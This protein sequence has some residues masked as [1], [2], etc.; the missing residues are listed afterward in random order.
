MD[1]NSIIILGN[2]FDVALGIETRYSQFYEK[3]KELREFA[4]NGN[5][6][7]QHILDHIKSELWSDLESGL[8]QYSKA[9][10]Q[11]YG[12]GNR[13]QAVKLEKEFNELRTALFDYLKTAAQAPAE[14]IQQMPVIGLNLEW[15]EL[16]PQFLTFNY[17]INTANTA[18]KNDRYIFN[19]DDS[20]NENR[21]VY[22]HGSIYDTQAYKNRNPEEIVVGID[23]T[24][25]Q[26]EPLHSFLYKTQQRLHDIDST[27]RIIRDKSFYVV[28]GCSVGDSDAT[29]F[30]EVF[31]RN[32]QGK[33]FLIYGYGDKAIQ[34]IMANIE[35]ICG[36]S[37]A[38]LSTYNTVKIL[39]V[40]K[41]DETRQITR[42]V[43]AQ[44]KL[45]LGL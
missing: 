1:T 38:K 45:S 17:S 7:C 28:Y 9:I 31:S 21:F 2:G 40:Q 37:I 10:T 26:V 33:I 16:M 19:A 14:V 41:V 11:Q 32:Q 36:I 6:L 3:S 34:D 43:I 22:Q 25:Q 44:Y 39:D 30:R 29:Y 18:S 27:L 23:S 35:R 15:H 5:T 12:E 24:I 13:E 42:E 8:Y 4:Q 20:I